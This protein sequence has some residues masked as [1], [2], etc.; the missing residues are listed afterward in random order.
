MKQSGKAPVTREIIVRM[1]S[2]ETGFVLADCRKLVNS[3]FDS[4]VK[5][6]L[7]EKDIFISR[8]GRIR[9]NTRSQRKGFDPNSGYQQARRLSFTPAFSMK[10]ALKALPMKDK[11]E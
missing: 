7:E 6:V 9:V 2:K 8:L 10:Q 11:T 4:V 5:C 1:V 3:A